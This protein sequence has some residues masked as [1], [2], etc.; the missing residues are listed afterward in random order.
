MGVTS[1]P[2]VTAVYAQIVNIVLVKEKII[3]MNKNGHLIPPP[4]ILLDII[5][6]GRYYCQLRYTKRGFPCIIKGNITEVINSDD[7]K[8][9]VEHQLPT[10]RG[11]Q[12]R[13]EF[14]NQRILK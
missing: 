10:L 11:K 13:I 6:N 9:F 4:T 1:N 5:K 12:Y 8:D 7:I 14:A 3:D 2:L